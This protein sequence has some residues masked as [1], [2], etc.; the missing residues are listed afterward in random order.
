MQ[1]FI[2][3]DIEIR[4]ESVQE[5][6]GKPPRWIIRRGIT[7]IMLVILT[8][9][10]GSY[11]YRYPDII[12]A[13]ITLTTANPPT[14]IIAKT[15]G[16]I[17][18][19]L[20]DDK[21]I[22]SEEQVIG[23]MENPAK[24][25]DVLMLKKKLEFVKSFFLNNLEKVDI[26]FEDSYQLGMIHSSYA[27][28]ITQ[29]QSYLTTIRLDYIGEQIES[30]KEQ[31]KDYTTYLS[32]LKEQ[33]SIYEKDMEL[34]RK[35]FNRDS[36]LFTKGVLADNAYETSKSGYLKQ[37]YG[38]KGSLANLTNTQL[39]I[40][41]LQ[42]QILEYRIKKTE[43][44][45]SVRSGLKEKFEV[46]NNQ[47]FTWEQTYLL[48]SAIKGR[49]TYTNTWSANQYI[50]SGSIVFTIVP[51]EEQPIIGR[52]YIP[53]SGSGK[54]KIGQSVNIKLDNYPYMEYGM[55]E[56]VIYNI[57]KVPTTE[58]RGTFYIAEVSLSH[59]LSTNYKIELPFHQEMQGISEI[60]TDDRRLIHRFFEPLKA[61][62]KEKV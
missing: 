40:N 58:Q 32:Q 44:E 59:N 5:I 26:T 61:L 49:V 28:F 4:S 34:T 47:I 62:F 55:L 27:A 57:S 36:L 6:L 41:Q 53:L 56:G 38:Y 18:S 52:I 16:K 51:E 43:Q 7:I 21:Q 22:V 45:E 19:I 35:Q 39:K 48:K 54:V 37:I 13:N 29:W 14:S 50:A 12:K 31:T 24:F 20:V 1:D 23:I 8:L 30:L 10:I 60:I 25:P 2:V 46:L 11:F 33:V 9:L 3:N 15:S 42:Q 17:V